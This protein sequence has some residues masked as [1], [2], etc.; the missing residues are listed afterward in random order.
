MTPNEKKE[1]QLLVNQFIEQ[2]PSQAR[3]A[4]ALKNV[5]EATLIQIKKGNWDNISDD[6]WRNVA[7]QVGYDATGV[8]RLVETMDFNTLITYLDDA[9]QYANVF[10]IVGPAGSGK[11]FTAD[12]YSK[13]KQNVY[14]VNCA[15]YFNRKMFLAKLLE[16]MGKDNTGYNV[17][18][19]MDLIVETILK[20]DKP[21]IILDEAD[22]LNDQVLYFFIT[23][24]N[25]LKGKC[26]IVLM[27]TDFLTK[28]INRGYRMNKKGYAEILSRIGRRFIQL[29]GI[30]KDEVKQICE[31]NELTNPIDITEVWN[32]CEQDLRRVERMVHKK[33]IKAQRQKAA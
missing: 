12:W 17:S 5:S 24:Y 8:W 10:A 16:K 23:M 6:M 31:A 19:M 25:N 1:V 26:G 4:A 3:A 13:R 7:K 30:N 9:R 20:Q 15:E 22:K 11:T 27:A 33:K 14:H 21:L 28:R 2:F 32:D 29:H 18:E